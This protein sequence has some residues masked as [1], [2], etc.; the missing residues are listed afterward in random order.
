MEESALLMEGLLERVTRRSGK[1]TA[2]DLRPVIEARK[3]QADDLRR[4]I[5]TALGE[6]SFSAEPGA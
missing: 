4:F 2:A 5:K 3:R 6:A 1:A